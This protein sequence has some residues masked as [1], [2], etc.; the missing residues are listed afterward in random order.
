MSSKST[1]RARATQKVERTPVAVIES[2]AVNGQPRFMPETSGSTHEPVTPAKASK[3]SKYPYRAHVKYARYELH[4]RAPLYSGTAKRPAAASNGEHVMV[5]D[6]ITAQCPHPKVTEQYIL[7][8]AGYKSVDDLIRAATF[9]PN[10]DLRP[11]RSLGA[12]FRPNAWAQGR[13]L[14]GILVAWI[15][16]DAATLI[17]P[18]E[19]GER[20]EHRLVTA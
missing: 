19:V 20:G 18:I 3:A 1:R 16:L 8:V 15:V 14:A 4:G 6:F 7:E 11:L 10:A 13:Y 2:S 5:R 17:A 12:N 9:E